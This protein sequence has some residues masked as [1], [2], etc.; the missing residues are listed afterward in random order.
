MKW[1]WGQDGESDLTG[2]R[3]EKGE[4][5]GESALRGWGGR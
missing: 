1:G 5:E 2:E 3:S 4:K